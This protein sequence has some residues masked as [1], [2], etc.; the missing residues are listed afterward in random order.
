MFCLSLSMG[1]TSEP[2]GISSILAGGFGKSG[3]EIASAG[4]SNIVTTA[5][6]ALIQQRLNLNN[7]FKLHPI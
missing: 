6:L 1:I 7:T 5:K 3:L 2:E 4:T